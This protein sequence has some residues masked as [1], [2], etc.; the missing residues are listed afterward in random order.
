VYAAGSEPDPRFT[1]ANERTF[2]AWIR[3]AL[4]LFAAGA[5]VGTFATGIEPTARG[6]VAL[7]LIGLGVLCGGVAFTRWMANEK[8]LRESRP[9]PGFVWGAVLSVGVG[10]VGL[11]LALGAAVR[12]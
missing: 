2:L 11:M 9:L 3:T 10:V 12:T 8:A 4:G 7:S 6:A 1:L 5:A